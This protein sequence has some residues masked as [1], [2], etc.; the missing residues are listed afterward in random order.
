M[1]SSDDILQSL[2]RGD[3]GAFD[4]VFAEYHVPLLLYATRL[5]GDPSSAEDIVQETFVGL[6]ADRH[7]ERVTGTLSGYLFQSVRNAALR[8]LRDVRRHAIT[9]ERLARD[10]DEAAPSP[11]ED[12]ITR[13]T[14]VLYAAIHD[15]PADRRRVFM[16]VCVEGLKYQEVADRLGISLNTVK[17]QMARAFHYLREALKD[18]PFSALMIFFLKKIIFPVTR[19]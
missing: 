7:H 1:N 5:L 10:M 16:L 9:H 13:E 11:L 8:H 4:A 17:K 18:K 19:N 15:L 14:D 6:W 12:E 3:P 2:R